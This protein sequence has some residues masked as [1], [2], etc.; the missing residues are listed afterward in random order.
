MI[1]SFL[2]LILDFVALI[3]PMKLNS[4]LYLHFV[5]HPV[6]LDKIYAEYRLVNECQLY[7]FFSLFLLMQLVKNTPQHVM[8]ILF[9][10]ISWITFRFWSCRPIVMK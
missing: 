9:R 8:C 1:S 4:I 7:K 5:R 6:L 3:A 2:A 10:R